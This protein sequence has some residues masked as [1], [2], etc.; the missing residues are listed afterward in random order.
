MFVLGNTTS[1][2]QDKFKHIKHPSCI[3]QVG[4]S[5]CSF[6]FEWGSAID[7]TKDVPPSMNERHAT[8][9][10]IGAQPVD[11]L[12]AHRLHARL[13]HH[14]VLAVTLG[15]RFV[16]GLHIDNSTSTFAA[17]IC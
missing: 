16:L 5:Q 17:S 14:R 15:I 1:R 10:H 8:M 6:F 7:V 3:T 2:E 11:A 4:S 9:E 12:L 13:V